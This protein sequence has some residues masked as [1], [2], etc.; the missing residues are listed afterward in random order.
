MH[1][2]YSVVKTIIIN[3]VATMHYTPKSKNRALKCLL[4]LAVILVQQPFTQ[5]QQASGSLPAINSFLLDVDCTDFTSNNTQS[6]LDPEVLDSLPFNPFLG[7]WE[8]GSPTGQN[9]TNDLAGNGGPE[10]VGGRT[11]TKV[12]ATKTSAL[13]TPSAASSIGAQVTFDDGVECARFTLYEWIDTGGDAGDVATIF[14]GPIG[15]S[16]EAAYVSDGNSVQEWRPISIDVSEYVNTGF[17]IVVQF[18]ANAQDQAVGWYL[19]DLITEVR[20]NTPP[21]DPMAASAT[22]KAPKSYVSVTLL[23]ELP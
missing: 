4:G 17:V 5:A 14:I 22:A 13:Y 15:E 18:A 3:E 12:I 8:I 6:F 9:G 19:D 23:N 21:V 1:S 10:P 11:G 2:V 16:L 20:T 7:D